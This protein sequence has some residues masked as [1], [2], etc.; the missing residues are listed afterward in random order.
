MRRRSLLRRLLDVPPP[1]TA[2]PSVYPTPSPSASAPVVTPPPSAQPTF[3]S[4]VP[5][6]AAPAAAAPTV[7]APVPGPAPAAGPPAAAP[8]AIYTPPPGLTRPVAPG[9]PAVPRCAWRRSTAGRLG[10]L[11]HARQHAQRRCSRTLLPVVTGD[12]HGGDAEVRAADQLQLRLVCGQSHRDRQGVG[13]QRRRSERHVRLS[14]VQ[15]PDA[16]FGVAGIRGSLLERTGVGAAGDARRPRPGRLAA[17][18][19]RRLSR[20]RLEPADFRCFRRGAEFPHRRLQRLQPRD[21][22]QHPL[23]GQGHGRA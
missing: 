21:Q 14:V 13:H 7:V 2:A 22:R 17:A 9:A 4:P 3:T 1:G 19:L 5:A 15:H 16:D 6:A 18:D 10:S 8:G 11:R 20:F 12:Q 23:H